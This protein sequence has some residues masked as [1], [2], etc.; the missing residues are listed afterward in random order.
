MNLEELRRQVDSGEVDTVYL[1][2]PDL[3]GRLKGKRHGA[4]HFLDHIAG[5]GAEMCAYV[6]ATDMDMHP[7]DGFELV[8]WST[9]YGDM[10]LV[11]DPATLRL[12][13]WIPRTALLLADA[14]GEDDRPV[15]VSPRRM[16]RRRLD[17]LAA[18]G[19]HV[20][21]GIE[22]EYILYEGTPAQ[23]HKR[24]YRKLRPAVTDNLDYALDHPPA[25]DH[26][27]RELS[28]GL[29]GAGLP[30]EAIKTE[31]ALGQVEVTF[32]YGDALAAADGHLVFKHAAKHIAE[33]A[34]LAATFMA[35][36]ETGVGNG[37]H[38]HLSLWTD[39]GV[40]LCADPEGNLSGLTRQVIAGLLDAL[41]ALTP[42]YAPTV[43]SYKR[44]AP[45][46]FAPSRY[47]WGR[48]NRTCA[49]RVVGH[50]DGLH[51]EVRLPGADANP[52]LALTAALAAA[53]H[54][55]DHDLKPPPPATGSAYQDAEAPSVAPTLHDALDAFRA[56]EL[57]SR[58]LTPAVAAHYA[59]AARTEL[60]GQRLQV[61]DADL[62]RG[63][64][65]A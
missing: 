9:G 55:I 12:L 62:R 39:D 37:L 31:A 6:L 52:Y 4:R 20:K 17:D 49:V 40:P 13:P 46:S 25:V 15:E 1:A 43:N 50:G 26:Y 48:D 3:Q 16:L 44:F 63:F 22:T 10:R 14:V 51:L 36:P 30:V 59:H 64:S 58:L 11:P 32:P 29:S 60:D 35:A 42:L 57:P 2:L 47:T 18:R 28:A 33:R 41:P 5:E 21:A 45:D 24:G 53:Q 8:S 61:T 54:G 38:L 27:F 19:I 56:G 7:L 23:A 65:R 34:G